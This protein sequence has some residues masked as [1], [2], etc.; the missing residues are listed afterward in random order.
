LAANAASDLSLQRGKRIWEAVSPHL[1]L[2]VKSRFPETETA[3]GRDRFDRRALLGGE[4]QN[5][6]LARPFGWQIAK[7]GD[8]TVF[9]YQR[10]RDY[11]I[12]SSLFE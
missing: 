1:S 4:A 10:M 3:A 7:T 12:L 9:L 5:L 11:C 6:V 8:L 2:A